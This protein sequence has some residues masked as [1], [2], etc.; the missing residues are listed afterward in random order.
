[1]SVLRLDHEILS[2]RGPLDCGALGGP[3]NP[4]EASGSAL[5]SGGV[6]DECHDEA[7]ETSSVPV[8]VSLPNEDVAVETSIPTDSHDD[9]NSEVSVSIPAT[10]VSQAFN[11]AEDT[12]LPSPETAPVDAGNT[13]VQDQPTDG[14]SNNN[15]D[16]PVATISGS[17]DENQ[18]VTMPIPGGSNG[19]PTGTSSEDTQP[20][21]TKSDDG[22][23]PTTHRDNATSKPVDDTTSKP[24]DNT[25]SGTT[26]SDG[27]DNDP[28]TKTQSD[29]IPPV[30]PKPETTSDNN[31]LPAP[32][33]TDFPE[34]LAPSTVT[35]HP[36]WVSN[37]WI[38]TSDYSGPTVVPVLV[39]CPICGGKG[40][41]IVLFGFPKVA[42]SWFKLSGL[43]KFK[44]P[45]IPPVCTTPPDTSENGNDDDDDENK[46]S[47]AT[48]TEKA[49]VAD[50]FVACTT[51]T[52]PASS[53]I[54]PEC[55]TTCTKT[56]TGCDVVGTTTTSSTAAC[57]PSGSSSCKS[58][59]REL[60]AEVEPEELEEGGLER[61]AVQKLKDIGGCNGFNMPSFPDYPGGNLVLDNDADIIPKNSPLKDIKKWWF[62]TP[63][64]NCV[65]VLKGH[66]TAAEAKSHV[67]SK[68]G[69]SIDH[70][71]EKSMLL[72]FFREII[73]KNG[74][75]IR[76]LSD[77]PAQK[78]IS[79]EDMK[80]YGGVDTNNN[81]L[82]K[83][84]NAYPQ[85]KD[86]NNK[87]NNPTA[88]RAAKY[89][90]DMIAMDQWTNGGAKQADS[91]VAAANDVTASTSEGDANTRIE[92]KI[93]E[94]EKLAIG[95]E[96]FSVPEALEAMAR[97]NQRLYSRFVDM[98]NNAKGCMN[99]D[100]V[101]NGIWSF[102]DGYK[103]F[104]A[105]RFDGTEAWSINAAVKYAKTKIIEKVTSDL[106]EAPNVAG[107]NQDE[108]NAKVDTWKARLSHKAGLDDEKW[109]VPVPDW[110]WD[111]VAKR[112]GDGLSCQRP[113]PS[114]TSSEEPTTFATSVRT[115]SDDSNTEKPSSE[116]M[117]SSTEMPSSIE[118]ATTTTKTGPTIGQRPGW[119]TD[120]PT[121]SDRIRLTISTPEGSSCTKTVTE[122]MC[123]QGV[124]VGHGQ[125][126]VTHSRC[127]AWVNT[128]TTS[129]PSPSP[130]AN[131]PKFSDNYTR[132][133]GRDGQVSNPNAITLAAQSFCRDV[134]AKNKDNGYYWS[135]DK[136]EGKKL[137]STGYHFKFE[138]S[139][140][141]GCL[142]KADYNE[143]MRYFQVP[144]DSCN[145][146][147]K[148]EKVGGWVKNN[149][150]T[151]IIDPKRGI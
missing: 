111:I 13:D 105:S 123:N 83:V 124:G 133:N 106:N 87:Q 109:G 128:K 134:V 40:S 137:L 12:G 100:A 37:T 47:S 149:C 23:Q 72:D 3:C 2:N 94:L 131:S 22:A 70:V 142:W 126:C 139:V 57:G 135:N 39:G 132:C 122:S 36:D 42:G 138:F 96:M 141:N 79:C 60:V 19:K 20:E 117:P 41:G 115:S 71:Y 151:A 118:M 116:E 121:L 136:L 82:Q 5:T 101:K 17:F 24:V 9:G 64:E 95:V 103:N 58:C 50:C 56:H 28:V 80:A 54:T 120:A 55:Q 88:V 86:S 44:F 14:Q 113:I 31:A 25:S 74:P 76:G 104:M 145:R 52:G 73:D 108:W 34:G 29:D 30:T 92:N 97:Q 114:E 140:A 78:K 90:D 61:R 1:M 48:C 11:G 144:I 15:G 91:L 68:N 33:I 127:E 65:P 62:T 10:A 129:K 63:G 18:S 27:G 150:I 148:G 59:Q 49:T 26:T 8:V 53:T 77:G 21:E 16:V 43:P 81:L 69:A 102:A 45:C 85:S 46:S 125:A 147:N 67:T 32:T 7:A 143:C 110:K 112:D 4:A 89:L 51:Y 6:P 38:T 93:D 146:N 99:N 98:D 75:D 119:W 66:L 130:T 107:T 35:G 84:F